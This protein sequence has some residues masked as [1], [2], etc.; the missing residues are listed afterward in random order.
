M[1]DPL[2]AGLV[3]SRLN[4]HNVN[5]IANELGALQDAALALSRMV[6]QGNANELG[7]LQDA[8]LA[9]LGMATR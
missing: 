5:V 8:P 4:D 1:T 6:V 2:D 3:L 9:L 7:A